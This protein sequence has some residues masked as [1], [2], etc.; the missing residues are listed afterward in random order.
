M[1]QWDMLAGIAYA[2]D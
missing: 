2:I 1:A